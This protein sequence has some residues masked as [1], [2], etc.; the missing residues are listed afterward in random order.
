MGSSFEP[1]PERKR[2]WAFVVLLGVVSLLA[3]MTYEGA[4]SLIGPFLGALGAGAAVVGLTAGLRE[5]IGYA[6]RLFMGALA[7]RTRGY[8]ALTIGGYGLNLLAVPALVLVGRWEAALR[9]VV[10]DLT[11]RSR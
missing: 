6:L 4:R 7:D 1:S 11:S 10:L 8:W 9:L 5:F 3:D 2:A